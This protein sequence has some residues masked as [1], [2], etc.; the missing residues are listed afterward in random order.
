M[1]SNSILRLVIRQNTWFTS[2]HGKICLERK[3]ETTLV[4]LCS[5]TSVVL[6]I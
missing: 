2:E 6:F 3:N 4:A 1:K 5:G